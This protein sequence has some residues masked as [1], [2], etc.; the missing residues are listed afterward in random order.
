MKRSV[1]RAV[2]ATWLP[3][4]AALGHAQPQLTAAK[5]PTLHRIK[6]LR[7]LTAQESGRGYPLDFRGVITYYDYP[8]GDIFL[9]DATGGVYIDPPQVPL[10]LKA[11]QYVEIE[12][13]SRPSD[14]MSDVANARINILS[15][16]SLPEARRV[17][18]HELPSGGHDCERVEVEGIVRSADALEGGVMLD[19]TTGL[20]DFKAYVPGVNQPPAGFVDAHVRIRGTCGGFYNSRKQFIAIEMLVPNFKDIDIV[21]HPPET[22]AALPV[23][24]IR[25]ILHANRNQ[26]FVHRVRVQGVLTLQ[27]PGRSLFIHGHDV[28]LLVETRQVTPLKIGDLVD[29]AGFPAL[30]DYGPV[31]QD[32]VFWRSGTAT[33]TKPI[34][35][36]AQQALT[37]SFDAELVQVSARLVEKSQKQGYQSLV[38]QSEKINFDAELEDSQHRLADVDV[39]SQVQLRGICSVRVNENREVK[40]FTILLRS[41]DDLVVLERPS[42]WTIKHALGVLGFTGV[43]ILLVLGWV[44][45]L[46][47]RV[48]DAQRQFTAF[49]DNIPA[50][51]FLKDANGNYLYT[52]RSFECLAG[53]MQGKTAFD[54]MDPESASQYRTHDS[55]VLSTGA[56]AEFVETFLIRGEPRHLWV[57]KFPVVSSGHRLLGGV[58]IDIT[59]RKRAEAELETAKEAA[60]AASRAKSEF[61]ANM[62]H[63]IRTPMNGILGMASLALDAT[64]RDEQREFLGD[65]ITSAESLLALLNDILD[66]SKIEAG[67]MELQ[68]APTSICEMVEEVVHFLRAAAAKKQLQVSWEVSPVVPPELSADQLRLRQV[69]LNLLGNAIK[70]TDQGSIDIHVDLESQDAI[71][72]TLRFSVHDTGPG[73]PPEKQQ[74]IFE[75]FRQADGSTTRKHGGTGLGLSISLRLVKMMGGNIWVNSR[76]GAGSTFCFTARFGRIAQ[77]LHQDSWSLHAKPE[78]SDREDA[79]PQPEHATV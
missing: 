47:R 3:I 21:E 40:G 55:H 67:R 58:A 34:A 51:A 25:T 22:Y 44:V 16:S 68:Q 33:P 77:D 49:M 70:F 15:E 72:T 28:G 54:W 78:Q 29:V 4:L 43:V 60:E 56:A 17:P 32:A 23:G 37:G 53:D 52:N 35:V 75:S 62:S 6:E 7:Q 79:A 76:P 41:P 39:G 66:L 24:S 50:V 42:W 59:E 73:I 10:S 14:F 9:Q 71:S 36:T 19:V 65:V 12:G 45:A 5:L 11:G 74:I 61:L 20:V 26:E 57:F 1:T 30:G 18:A 64:D 38:L 27:R 13:V 69:L 8:H 31:L 63:E 46:R 2:I 48:R